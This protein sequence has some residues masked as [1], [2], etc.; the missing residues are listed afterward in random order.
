MLKRHNKLISGMFKSTKKGSIPSKYKGKGSARKSNTMNVKV[1]ESSPRMDMKL[2][3]CV[4]KKQVAVQEDYSHKITESR[5]RNK[6]QKY[7]GRKVYNK[8]EPRSRSYKGRNVYQKKRSTKREAKESEVN[9]FSPQPNNI[10]NKNQLLNQKKNTVTF[11]ISDSEN[12]KVSRKRVHA[13]PSKTQDI[14]IKK[15]R[16]TESVPPKSEMQEQLDKEWLETAPKELSEEQ[17]DYL[18][19][20]P[21]MAERNRELSQFSGLGNASTA[22]NNFGLA[23]QPYR[24]SLINNNLRRTKASRPKSVSK[25]F[26]EKH[27]NKFNKTYASPRK[28]IKNRDKEEEANTSKNNKELTPSKSA[29]EVVSEIRSRG[30]KSREN[31]ENKN[32]SP[33]RLFF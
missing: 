7:K 1:T 16:K 29:I 3:P 14:S 13:S 21:D 8:S 5:P 32:I 22:T 28:E 6:S 23:G 2:V 31:L 19:S 33:K 25:K 9:E 24:K 27:F 15:R 26:D 12:E 18:L 4:Q 17:K 10:S 30:V 20:I 11:K